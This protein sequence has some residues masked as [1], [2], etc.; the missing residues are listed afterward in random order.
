MTAPL[1][2]HAAMPEFL[3]PRKDVE[4]APWSVQ[5]GSPVRGDAWTNFHDRL[6]RVPFGGDDFS[7]VVRAHEMMHAQVSPIDK[8]GIDTLGYDMRVMECSEEFRVNTLIKRAGFDVDLLRDGSESRTGER[9]AERD[10]WRE[11][12]CFLAAVAGT[13]AAQDY[14]RGVQRANE[15]WARSLRQVQ[16]ALV[17]CAKGIGNHVMGSTL[18]DAS[19]SG[20][21]PTGF[22]HATRQFAQIVQAAITA[23]DKTVETFDGDP[24][25][26]VTEEVSEE[27]VKNAMD[28]LTGKAGKFATLLLDTAVPLPNH[29]KGNLGRKRIATNIGRSPRRINRVLTD[30]E[31]RIF[32]KKTKGMGGIVLIDQSGSMSLSTEDIWSIVNAA[33]GCVIIGYS[34]S[35][36]STSTPNTW[37]LADRGKVCEKVREGNGGNG[38]DGPALRFALSKR[39]TGE[40][41]IWVCDG[42]FTDGAADQQYPNLTEEC[43][44]L[45]IRHGVHMVN[46]V[47]GA[48]E[49]LSRAKTG[50]RL[51]TSVPARLQHSAAWRAYEGR[52]LAA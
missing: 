13:K 7:R 10:D 33:P 42:V 18:P 30:P 17:K 19:Y 11:A 38:V 12:V 8:S 44:A 32:D 49:A 26:G 23:G 29:V 2:H 27:S 47:D 51:P 31:R 5:E 41:V 9:I 21:L 48:L 37:V 1:T 43:V 6:M 22:T 35:A 4:G 15:E 3:R 24:I 39:K 36:G 14:L 28:S 20:N 40:P 52:T 50:Q 45:V 25:D 34:H 46:N 16:K